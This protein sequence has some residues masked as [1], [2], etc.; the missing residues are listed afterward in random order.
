MGCAL[1]NR[2]S[3]CLNKTENA[4]D[5]QVAT[6]GSPR[7]FYNGADEVYNQCL[8]KKT[9]RVACQSDPLRLYCIELIV[10]VNQSKF[11]QLI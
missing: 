6:F 4:E 11:T 5:V 1:A 8:G 7:V 9:I 10:H 2:A 3:L